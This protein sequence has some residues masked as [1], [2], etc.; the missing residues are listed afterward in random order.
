MAINLKQCDGLCHQCI[1]GYIGKF[2]LQ[3]GDKFEVRCNGIPKQYI[4]DSVLATIG[5]DSQSAIAMLDPVTW[6][7]TFLDWHCI[8]P[9]GAIWKRKTLDGTLKGLPPYEE[10]DHA[11][12]IKE[13][14]S[15]FNRP[16]QALML[17]CTS[18]RKIFRI[19]RQAGKSESLCVT[20][21]Y[22]LFT[23]ENFAI[24]VIAPY[25]SQ[26]DL[27]FKRLGELMSGNPSLTNSIARSVK[28]PNY[29]IALKNESYVI[30][31]TAGTRSGQEAGA[32]RGQ[33]A[34]MLIFDECFVAGTP[35]ETSHGKV[36]IEKVQVGDK[37]VAFDEHSRSFEYSL[38][39]CSQTNG[40]K[41][42][43]EYKTNTG[44]SLIC[45]KNHPIWDGENFIPI[46]SASRLFC[47]S[48]ILKE[49]TVGCIRA[50]LYGSLLG[51]GWAYYNNKGCKVIG[52]SGSVFGLQEIQGDIRELGGSCSKI[53]SRQT[54]SPNY[55]IRGSTNHIISGES[56]WN[57][58]EKYQFPTGKKVY[59]KYVVSPLIMEG[60][61]SV[62]KNFL[63]AIF[64]AEGDRP[65]LQGNDRT[66]RTVSITFTKHI[67]LE[68]NL[69][70]LM[71]QL[72]CLLKGLDIDHK[73]IKY[74]GKIQTKD[75]VRY[76]LR[77]CNRKKNL[78]KFFREI[79]Y[80]YDPVKQNEAFYLAHYLQGGFAST[81]SEFKVQYVDP[82][83]GN[84]I[85][86]IVERIFLGE[87]EVFNLEVEGQHT[88]IA[89][90]VIVHNCDYLK[91][92]DIDSALA[93]I[94]NHPDATV[95]MSS[96]PTGRREKFYASCNNKEYKEFHFPSFVNPN[97]TD[98]LDK[99]YRTEFTL[100]GYKH[101][102]L[103]EFG[104]QEEGVY[105]LKY[106]EA[107]QENFEYGQLR[108]NPLWT[109][110]IGVDWN[111]VKIGT[112]IAVVG[113]NPNTSVFHLVD[114]CIVSR[115]ERTQLTAC[116]KIADLNRLWS[117]AAI[118]VD[119]GYGSVQIEVL[120]DF[121]Q[122]SLTQYGANHP[123]SRLRLLVKGY[124]FG[125]SIDIRDPFTKQIVKKPA[126]PFLVENSVRRFE[127]VQFKYPMSD[128]HFTKQLSGYIVK[129]VS[130]LGRPI[131]EA[132]DEKAGDH[133]LDAVNLA[134]VAFTQEKGTF[135]KPQ[136]DNKI[137]FA[138][139]FGEQASGNKNIGTTFE[140]EAKDHLPDLGRTM[141]VEKSDR[142]IS[143]AGGG[144]PASHTAVESNVRPWS[145]PGFG[146]DAP[147]PKTRSLSEFVRQANRKVAGRRGRRPQRS[148]F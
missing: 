46:E 83:T 57:E 79:S 111:D 92:A 116:Q 85:L 128:D 62:K 9:D 68:E 69:K 133:F 38:V 20:I 16:Y 36:S 124:D 48:P 4:P 22:N 40:L 103:A 21:L 80:V 147:A 146:S 27:I 88:Y 50:R 123:D 148:K 25:Q 101:E 139:R 52:F 99:Y 104:E 39:S 81:Y 26:I 74:T 66:P 77:I 91:P 89:N 17:R 100:D 113:W 7:S 144:L 120:H 118:Y 112:T 41:P 33:H 142:L 96:T 86:P 106:I 115:A 75:R 43:Y 108:P 117:P 2:K 23:H 121:G 132:Q 61:D 143:P 63:A 93:V 3:K 110:M 145:W 76:E 114:K 59:T 78:V 109:Y 134:L 125:G 8:D 44:L 130:N 107:A 6:A 70:S 82:N 65:A 30:G 102:V 47:T 24:Q 95:W 138:G 122:R 56:I 127:S 54:Y 60:T 29:Q 18:R 98:E 19:G 42:V 141:N 49:T 37:V 28:A 12:R 15:I 71:G 84:L 45:T 5:T 140:K 136:Y 119:Q 35:I 31:F 87:K 32:A 10:S 129:R 137:S 64:G 58:L 73:I 53:N 14:K 13:G 1:K 97:Y 131:Y 90:N 67:S 34:N 105:Q 126:K 94:T 51:D 135:G 55:G 72:S 11:K